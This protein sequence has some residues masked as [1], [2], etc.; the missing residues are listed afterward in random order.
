MGGQGAAKAKLLSEWFKSSDAPKRV[1]V[2][3]RAGDYSE[4]LK[5][6]DMPTVLA[7]EL[8][9]EQIRQFATN[10]LKEKADGL[11][12]RVLPKDKEAHDDTRSLTRLARNPYMLGAL[13]Y[14]YEKSPS[15]DLPT[16]VGALFQKLVRALWKREELRGTTQGVPFEWAEAEFAELAF[17]MIYE[18][19]ATNVP[20]RYA[21]TKIGNADLLYIGVNANYLIIN[22]KQVEFYHQLMQEYFAAAY[23]KRAGVE[24]IFQAWQDRRLYRE[25]EYP[26]RDPQ[27]RHP[28]IDPQWRQP[29]IA[30]CG[31]V[32]DPEADTILSEIAK[33]D[34]ILA[35]ECIYSGVAVSD[36]TRDRISSELLD[37]MS[38]LEAFVN[39]KLNRVIDEVESAID[40]ISYS[41]VEVPD[42]ENEIDDIADEISDLA[43]TI[44]ALGQT[45]DPRHLASLEE[46]LGYT[47]HQSVSTPDLTDDDI[48]RLQHELG[49]NP[50]KLKILLQE[51][52]E[53]CE[54]L[55]EFTEH[56]FNDLR[57]S[58]LEAIATIGNE[59][60]IHV[61]LC[62]F[63]A[64]EA[65]LAA[66][67]LKIGPR[68][69]PD[70][71]ER[72]D[73]NDTWIR[74][75][76][77]SVLGE[78]G[79]PRAVRP[80]IAL[81]NDSTQATFFDRVCDVAAQALERI[82]TPEALVAVE[83]WRKGKKLR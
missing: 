14:L 82:G 77:A 40:A 81:L 30:L 43:A 15:G 42:V 4:D 9:D 7:Q 20:L 28:P 44:R 12:A 65:G 41:E 58:I 78:I 10:Y 79:D 19:R 59:D 35:A 31:L 25:P 76:A 49:L 45:R 23:L 26:S 22:G 72:L 71:I 68:V 63:D 47:E 61:L 34:V 64:H 55:N 73:S 2:T 8:D 38:E 80:L 74:E 18:N 69:V 66:R 1:I 50:Y 6:D 62:L 53:V 37:R 5:L 32:D 29:L 48:Y 57:K 11:L 56:I 46:V 21:K 67:L 17:A 33:V 51:L 16:N 27:W 54:R 52:N 39:E 3:C 60:A 24:S 83:N 13:I 36:K 70:L 75:R